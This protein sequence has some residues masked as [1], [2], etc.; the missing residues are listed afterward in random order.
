MSLD[1]Y[2][3]TLVAYILASGSSLDDKMTSRFR[4]LLVKRGNN[5]KLERRVVN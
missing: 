1:T 2:L 5:Q 3:P 4:D